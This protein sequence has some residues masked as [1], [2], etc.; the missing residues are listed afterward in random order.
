MIQQC[1]QA[2]TGG[3]N[4]NW[5]PF[6]NSQYTGNEGKMLVMEEKQIQNKRL[7]YWDYLTL[8]LLAGKW[9]LMEACKKTKKQKNTFWI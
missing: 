6:R 2:M 8:E 7:M 1:L 5:Y 4:E 3:D 9:L